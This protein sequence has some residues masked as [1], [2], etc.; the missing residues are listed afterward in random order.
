MVAVSPA[1]HGSLNQ[2]SLASEGHVELGEGPSDSVAVSL[3]HQ[4]I[5]AVLLLGAAGTR[6]NTVLLLE[7][8]GKFFNIDRFHIAA[9]GVLHLYPVA[10]ILECDPL[11]TVA[12][13][14]NH[15][16]S[17]RGDWTGR[18]IGVESLSSL[19]INMLTRLSGALQLSSVLRM[20]AL[21]HG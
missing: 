2:A 6:V 20:L 1:V 8:W 9:D 14:S 4:T 11:H 16:R 13:L 21:R 18:R 10:R 19:R 3:V 7:L 12:I 5:A 17:R 15:E